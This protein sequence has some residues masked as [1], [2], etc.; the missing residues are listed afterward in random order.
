MAHTIA[1]QIDVGS[2]NWSAWRREIVVCRTER[3]RERE[4]GGGER[5]TVKGFSNTVKYIS[6]ENLRICAL[7]DLITR[8]VGRIYAHL[9]E[10]NSSLETLMSTT[11]AS[12]YAV[13]YA[14]HFSLI[15]NKICIR[16][17]RELSSVSIYRYNS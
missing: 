8:P 9:T 17:E 16:I 3:E 7:L 2:I 10:S 1:S 6:I 13:R 11:E 4:R 12:C 15:S 5:T 14:Q